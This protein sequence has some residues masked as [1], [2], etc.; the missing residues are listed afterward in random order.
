LKEIQNLLKGH[1][2]NFPIE[3]LS[4]IIDRL[5]EVELID[6]SARLKSEIIF[7]CPA[8]GPISSICFAIDSKGMQPA[9]RSLEMNKI[10]TDRFVDALRMYCSDQRP[11][12][13][14]FKQFTIDEDKRQVSEFKSGRWRLYGFRWREVFF[15]T[16]AS[17]K[18][19]DRDIDGYLDSHRIEDEH[20]SRFNMHSRASRPNPVFSTN[21]TEDESFGQYLARL[22]SNNKKH[23]L[24]YGISLGA[25]AGAGHHGCVFN[26][27][28]SRD[29]VVKFT[30]NID[31]ALMADHLMYAYLSH[32]FPAIYKILDLSA[33]FEMPVFAIFKDDISDVFLERYVINALIMMAEMPEPDMSVDMVMTLMDNFLDDNLHLL[34]GLPSSTE[35]A[36]YNFQLIVEFADFIVSSFE[37]GIFL[38]DVS[39][40]NL[41]QRA[42]GTIVLR[43]FGNCFF[44]DDFYASGFGDIDDDYSDEWQY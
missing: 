25:L 26:L 19:S 34:G 37:H 43:D 2:E 16:N 42:D 35:E 11:N 40:N 33:F 31:E 10:G 39:H 13:V 12:N 38:G 22:V 6:D 41:G 44:I 20:R 3:L 14:T 21:P 24:K 1:G 18:A 8:G 15:A 32:H 36:S 5:P 29:T 28:T 4:D 7:Q 9:R 27:S 23:L 30:T 17:F